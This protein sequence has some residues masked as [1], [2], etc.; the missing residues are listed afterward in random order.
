MDL[1][2]LVIT[3]VI[4]GVVLWLVNTYVPMDGKIKRILNIAVVVLVVLW[5]LFSVLG[6]G[7][8]NLG[9]VRIG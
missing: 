5:L 3:L 7:G 6:L 1:I 9:A 4:V 8:G 2:T